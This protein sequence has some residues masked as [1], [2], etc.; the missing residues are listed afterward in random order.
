MTL[1][2]F[3]NTGKPFQVEFSI[4]FV[5]FP[6][7]LV[8]SYYQC[9]IIIF[10]VCMRANACVYARV[11]VRICRHVCADMSNVI[12]NCINLGNNIFA[13]K[14][15]KKEINRNVFTQISTPSLFTLIANEL[16]RQYLAGFSALKLPFNI[17]VIFEKIL[18]SFALVPCIIIRCVQNSQ[19][20][21][22]FLN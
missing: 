9:Q 13:H 11:R 4:F 5:V 6:R 15:F 8:C 22:C 17:T 20:S 10:L 3:C 14:L 2:T 12:Y 21:F 18:I 19:M 1:S 16:S 7:Y